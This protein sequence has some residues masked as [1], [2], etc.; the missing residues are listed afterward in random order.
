M[1]A[2]WDYCAGRPYAKDEY[3]SSQFGKG[4]VRFLESFIHLEK[5]NVLDYGCGPGFLIEQLLSSGA[6]VSGVD[7]SPESVSQ[8]RTRFSTHPGW[9]DSRV[10]DGDRIPWNDRSFDLVCCIETIEHVLDEQLTP[11]LH[12]CKRLLKPGGYVLLTTPNSEELSR[13]MVFCPNCQLEFHRWQHIRSWTPDLLRSELERVGFEVAFCRGVNFG[14]FQKHSKLVFY[15]LSPRLAI[16]QLRFLA[17][18]FMDS[19]Y[20]RDFPNGRV[21]RQ[22][23]E[24][25]GDRHLVAVAMNTTK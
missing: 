17:N 9:I 19:V 24:S 20:P 10:L 16:S 15:D 18:R 21:F 1:K 6:L 25:H 4:V 14:V 11:L 12:E 13:Q 5:A 7:F 3:F 2:F 22:L 8:L 23:I